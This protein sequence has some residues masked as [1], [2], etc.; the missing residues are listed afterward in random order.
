MTPQ[1]RKAKGR[2]LQKLVVKKILALMPQLTPDD[3]RSTSMG[4]SGVDVLLSNAAKSA[5]PYAPE[6]KSRNRISIYTWFNQCVGNA[7]NEHPVLVIKQNNSE[8]LAI[9]TLDHF[10][11]LVKEANGTKEN[12]GN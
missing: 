7:G 10:L 11:Q 9:V 8:P 12:T 3:V 5:F 2:N 6:C 1:S 4:A